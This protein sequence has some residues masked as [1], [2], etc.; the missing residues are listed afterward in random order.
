DD[1]VRR[2]VPLPDGVRA[3]GVVADRRPGAVR[4]GEDDVPHGRDRE[5]RPRHLLLQRRGGD[6][7]PRRGA[8]ARAVA[9]G[10]HVRPDAA[11][12]RARRHGRALPGDRSGPPRL[13]PLQLRQRG[14]GGALRGTTGG[15]PGGG[16]G[17]PLPGAR[18]PERRAARRHAAHHGGP[19]QLR[20]D[21][22]S[23]HRRPAHGAHHQP[24][25]V[26]HR[27]RR[28]AGA[29]AARRRAARRGPDGA[30]HAGR[31]ATAGDD[32]AG[33]E[34]D[35]LMG[36]MTDSRKVGS[37][38]RPAAAL[39]AAFL[40][41]VL[42]SFRPSVSAQ[43]GYEPG[44]SPYRDIPRGGVTLLAFGYLGGAL[45]VAVGGRSPRDT[46]R[47]D[48]GTKFAVMPEAGIRWYPVRRVSVRVDFRAVGWKVTYPATYKYPYNQT[49]VL[50]PTAPLS[51]WTW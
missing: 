2:D 32:G 1:P 26:P 10:R 28:R 21:D 41:S 50:E 13:H 23:H 45:G 30:A 24:G 25:P 49:P 14:H 8:A 47:Y 9:E 35:R 40:L 18:A 4:E 42:P 38:L 36:G 19:R 29:A 6:A 7:V 48:F 27:G 22:R 43:V 34:G 3:D 33:F 51:E 46:S 15:G 16:D 20:A 39:G 12:E 31:G 17:R 5:V 11:D 44:H 37:W